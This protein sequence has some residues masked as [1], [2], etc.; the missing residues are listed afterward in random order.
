VDL[1][2]EGGRLER[3]PGFAVAGIAVK[4]QRQE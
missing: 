3:L 4:R 2:D 1:V